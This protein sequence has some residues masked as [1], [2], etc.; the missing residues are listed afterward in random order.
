[1]IIDVHG[2]AVA[3][4]ELYSLKAHI[5]GERGWGLAAALP[6]DDALARAAA[7][8]I[9]FLDQVGTDIQLVAPRPYML[10]C[11][12]DPA[13]VALWVA[14]YNEA[15]AKQCACFPDRLFGLAAL[16]QATG[17]PIADWLG[18]L[19]RC[20]DQFG[21]VGAV[22]NPDPGEGDGLTPGL[23]DRF[24]YPLWERLVA[25]DT[26]AVIVSGVS[27]AKRQGYSAHYVTEADTAILSLLEN[28]DL[29]DA[30][31]DLRLVIGYGAGSIPYQIDR[32]RARRW[33]QPGRESFDVS[34][35]RLWFDTVVH[36]PASLA[37]LLDVCG[38]DRCLFGTQR[39]GAASVADPRTGR[40]V[41]DLKPVIESLP[42]LDA[43]QRRAIFEDNARNVFPR[44]PARSER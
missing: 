38:P 39:P 5:F 34:L 4:A 10:P 19:D 42:G 6:S 32:W 16:P 33:R 36:A 2:N 35:R 43:A 29:F 41:D 8:H 13:L 25:R 12:E 24:W 40:A 23:G 44:L 37:I 26:P 3:M 30:F 20:L 9:A 31:P 11:R 18:E 27:R 22:I 7:S 15:I 21:F 28:A 14:Q 17:T 1:M